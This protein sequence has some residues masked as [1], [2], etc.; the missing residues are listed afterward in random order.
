MQI[1]L[2]FHWSRIDHVTCNNC[3]KIMICSCTMSSTCVWLQIIFC[4]FVNETS[5]S[6]FLWIALAWKWKITLQI[7]KKQTWWLND[8]LKQ[9]LILV[10]TKYRDFSVFHRSIICLSLDFWQIIIDLLASNK[11]WYFAKLHPIIVKY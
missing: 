10:I 4:S 6:S 8:K 1:F 11:S 2:P 5:L 3:L 7:I 9:L